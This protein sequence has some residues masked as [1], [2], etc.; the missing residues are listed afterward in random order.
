MVEPIKTDEPL[1]QGVG[2]PVATKPAHPGFYTG[3]DPVEWAR[4]RAALYRYHNIQLR[5]QNSASAEPLIAANER[6]IAMFE[7]LLARIK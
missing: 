4:N 2:D 1:P 6:E 5:E 3:E 7:A